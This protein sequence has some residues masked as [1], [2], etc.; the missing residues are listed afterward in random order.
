MS[1]LSLSLDHEEMKDLAE[2]SALVL[3][4]LAVS[5]PDGG[6]LQAQRW[7]LLVAKVFENAH[8]VPEL[9]EHIELN[10][11][12]NA[13]YFK[14]KYIEEAFYE[15]CLDEYRDTI[16]WTELVSRLT[17]RDVTDQLGGEI[18]EQLPEEAKTQITETLEKSY[19]HECMTHGVE[20]LHFILPPNEA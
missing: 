15:D 2:M 6:A 5:V 18:A 13:W 9:A 16:F 19:W 11:D 8:K 10:P 3:S 14:R 7:R 20:R 17:E 1:K 12:C 4:M